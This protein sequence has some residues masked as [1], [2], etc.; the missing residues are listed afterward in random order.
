MWTQEA[1]L[2]ENKCQVLDSYVEAYQHTLDSEEGFA[3]PQMIT[4]I[5]HQCPR[6]ILNQQIERQ[7]E[8]V[9]RLCLAALIPRA[10]EHFLQE[11]CRTC[12]PASASGLASLQQHVLPLALDLWLTPAEPEAWY[13]AQL[14]NDVSSF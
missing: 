10:L 5:T 2:L 6:R 3:L 4:D 7:W 1:A 9:Q 14:Q 13:S 11:V 12:K 8:Y